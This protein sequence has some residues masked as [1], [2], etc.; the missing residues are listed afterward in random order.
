M[1]TDLNKAKLNNMDATKVN[2]VEVIDMTKPF[3]EGGGR[4]FVYWDDA[5]KSKV[6]L[7]LQDDNRTLKV[8]I[9]PK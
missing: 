2:R 5:M 7:V 4:T 3:E 9:V 8:F 6:E 1:S